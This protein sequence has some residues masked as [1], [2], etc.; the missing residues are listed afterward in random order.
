MLK[1]LL[2]Q[3]EF[4]ILSQE[5]LKRLEFKQNGFNLQLVRDNISSQEK[6]LT[7]ILDIDEIRGIVNRDK[8]A[9]GKK[10]FKSNYLEYDWL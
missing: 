7:A 5:Y 8:E 4:D 9:K 3:V 2:N 10:N 6:L 1:Q